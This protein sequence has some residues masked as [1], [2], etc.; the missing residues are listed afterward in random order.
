MGIG[1]FF[2]IFA[3]KIA[4]NIKFYFSNPQKALPCTESLHLTY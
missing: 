1:I 3:K 2:R 4:L